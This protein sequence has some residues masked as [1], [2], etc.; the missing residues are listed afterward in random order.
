[1]DVQTK[2][3]PSTRDGRIQVVNRIIEEI[4]N[5]GRGFFYSDTTK[6][7]SYFE[8]TGK[9]LWFIDKYTGK[10]VYP[11]NHSAHK[12]FSEGGTLWGL[13]NDM[14]YFIIH[15]EHSNGKYGYGGLRCEHWG[16]EQKDMLAIQQLAREL[17]YL[18]GDR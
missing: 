13:V 6:Q 3:D 8:W 7:T 10:R 5:R 4:A 12:G 1:M 15:G 11:Y 18:R 17:R 9:K 14:R 2:L 16:Y